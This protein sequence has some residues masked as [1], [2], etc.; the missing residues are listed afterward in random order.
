MPSRQALQVQEKRELENKEESTI[1]ARAFLPTADIYES[2]DDLTVV[3]EMPGV[4][5]SGVTVA[6][7]DDVLRVEG[8]I[9]LS[10]YQG[11]VP[12]IPSTTSAIMEGAS[13]SQA[14]SIRARLKPK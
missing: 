5:R 6:V 1:P 9:D 7:Q 11:L 10:K 12:L 13:V 14:R 8:Q 2:Q 3:L 4:D